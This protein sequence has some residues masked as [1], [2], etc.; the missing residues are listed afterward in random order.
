MLGIGSPL[1]YLDAAKFDAYWKLD[2]KAI[3]QAVNKMG[4]IE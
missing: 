4:K 3:A 1:D 2:S